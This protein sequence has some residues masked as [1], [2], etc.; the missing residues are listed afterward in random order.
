MD[1]GAWKVHGVAKSRTQL[2]DWAYRDPCI[3]NDCKIKEI[4]YKMLISGEMITFIWEPSVLSLQ[5]FYTFKVISKPKAYFKKRS[6][7]QNRIQVICLLSLSFTRPSLFPSSAHLLMYSIYT[8][9]FT[10]AER[11]EMSSYSWGERPA[12]WLLGLKF[13]LQMPM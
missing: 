9:S 11:L 10:S 5:L 6:A 3:Q 4:K 2:R 13:P 1:R 12:W 8:R 7:N